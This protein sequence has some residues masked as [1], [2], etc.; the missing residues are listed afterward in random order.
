MADDGSI[1]GKLEAIECVSKLAQRTV[2][3]WPA[4]AYNLLVMEQRIAEIKT[5]LQN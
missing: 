2:L 5:I 3:D 1:L 4:V